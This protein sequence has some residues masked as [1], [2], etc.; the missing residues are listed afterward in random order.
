MSGRVSV[1]GA[2]LADDPVTAVAEPA[3]QA[4]RWVTP[5]LSVI[6]VLAIWQAVIMIFA[7]E[8]FVFPAPS[9]IAV[10]LYHGV[11][12]GIYVTAMLTTMAEVLFGFVLGSAAAFVLGVLIVA[13][14]AF[15]RAAYPWVVALQ[16]VPKVAIAPLMIVWFGFGM[17]AKVIVVALT[18]LFP[19]LVNTIAGLRTTEPERIALLRAMACSRLQLLRY[20]EIP[21][22]LPYVF[23]GLNTAMV[24]AII[25]A[26][27]AEFVG[28][29]SG[30][31]VL[32]L[33]ANMSL[34]LAGVFA[35]LTLLALA[36]LALS[37]LIERLG[38]WI[39]FWSGSPKR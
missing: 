26:I 8:P 34:D 28:A 32:V 24:L 20:I 18:C 19:V 25:G 10:A 7:V 16:T 2:S 15:G 33:Q 39:C 1:G 27:V 38:K 36:G 17:D 4:S 30:I 12:S 9:A 29:R 14:P 6:G 37:S 3:R 31:G 35:L 23:A 13:V 5:A 21:S 22:A 11:L